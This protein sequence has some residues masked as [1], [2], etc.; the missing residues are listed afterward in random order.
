MTHLMTTAAK[1]TV[2]VVD[3]DP[4][5]RRSLAAMLQAMQLQVETHET[6]D[7]FLAAFDESQPGCL[8][9]DL[10]LPGMSGLI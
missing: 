7:E 3:D 8:I 4:S 9:L 5:I 2:F 10:R 6:A 1:P